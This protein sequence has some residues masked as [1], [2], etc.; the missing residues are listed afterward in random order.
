MS[1]L[2][3]LLDGLSFVCLLA[4][5]SFEL[6]RRLLAAPTAPTLSGVLRWETG[7]VRYLLPS[8]I[9]SLFGFVAA[10]CG[11][12]LLQLFALPCHFQLLRRA[13]ELQRR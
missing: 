8:L 4:A 6:Q 13:F 9:S 3:I 2:I 7:S 5:W 10:V 12:L 1:R 11:Y